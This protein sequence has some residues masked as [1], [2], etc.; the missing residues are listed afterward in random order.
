MRGAPANKF[1]GDRVSFKP[2]TKNVFA[3]TGWRGCNPGYI[4]T[5]DGIVVVDSPQLPTNAV[6]MRDEM[7]AKGPV[8]FRVNTENH[9]DHIF[10]QHFLSDLGP[11]I[12]HRDIV[13]GYWKGALGKD[14]YEFMVNAVKTQDPAGLAIMPA[15]DEVRIRPPDVAFDGQLTLRLGDHVIE[16]IHTPG[17][18]KGQIAVY[19][20]QERVAFVGDTIFSGCQTWLQVAHPDMWVQS[21]ERIA[22]L[23]VDH[24]VP[25]HGPVCTRSYIA[26]QSAF[27]REWIA[28]VAAGIAKGW[29]RSECV[30]RISFV[31]RYPLDV[32]QEHLVPLVQRLNVEHL[33][34]YLQG[35]DPWG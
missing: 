27:I 26:T 22:A 2:V 24:I 9:I 23:D 12:G 20:P 14:P 13:A 7:L 32:G 6:L 5:A 10:G 29:S 35:G 33:Y 16:L 25:G 34:D 4:V 30:A 3:A 15:R 28:A 11:L 31:D 1:L 8:R 17:H 21:L 19:V 18:T